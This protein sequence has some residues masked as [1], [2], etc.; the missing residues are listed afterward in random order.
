MW[1]TTRQDMTNNHW[2]PNH[3]VPVLQ[4]QEQTNNGHVEAI[5]ADEWQEIDTHTNEKYDEPAVSSKDGIVE[6]I[7]ETTKNYDDLESKTDHESYDVNK[8]AHDE[9]NMNTSENITQ[10]K[11]NISNSNY[12]NGERT[13]EKNEPE[14][15][16]DEIK[17]DNQDQAGNEIKTENLIMNR[18]ADSAYKIPTEASECID[19]Y[20]IVNYNNT[21]YLGYVEDGDSSDIF[22]VC[23]HRVCKKM[24][25]NAFF[26]P[27]A[28]KDKCWYKQDQILAIIPEPKK[29]EGSSEHFE[30]DPDIWSRVLEKV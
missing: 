19:K 6:G 15:R 1:T 2:V 4:I 27:T 8:M 23:M 11:K 10:D 12:Q 3:F 29:I 22:V 24:E 25:M 5:P 13:N 26:W 9:E 28:V 30:V 21:P 7:P 14:V 18:S 16:E 17:I 20:V